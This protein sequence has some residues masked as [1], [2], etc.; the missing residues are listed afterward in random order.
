[1]DF[2]RP[3]RRPLSCRA[4]GPIGLDMFLKKRLFPALCAVVTLAAC[5]DKASLERSQVEIIRVEGRR[6]EVR[7]AP[8]DVPDTYRL[9]IVRATLVVDPEPDTERSRAWNVAR[10]IM[11][12]TCKGRTY[13]IFEDNLVDNV[14]LFTR[15]RCNE[16]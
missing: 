10:Q 8:T 3:R 7:V 9:M 11:D 14:N 1:M 5:N 2:G 13:K 16:A 12:R 4:H 6:Y 15:F